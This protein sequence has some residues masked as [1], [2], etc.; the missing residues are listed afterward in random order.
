M[1]TIIKQVMSALLFTSALCTCGQGDGPYLFEEDGAWVSY[2]F[3]DGNLEKEILTGNRMAYELKVATDV[4]GKTFTVRLKPGL[5]YELSGYD[6]PKKLVAI[7]DI[8]GNFGAF[9]KLLQATEV[10][11]RDLKWSFG[12]GHLVLVGDFFDRGEMVT[13]VLWLIYKL[14]H[15]A[16]DEGGQV[17]FIL[18]NHETM[19]LY[20]DLRYVHSKYGTSAKLMGRKPRELYG[21]NT[22]LGQWLRT[23]NVVEKVGNL[24]FAHA[25]VSKEVN[26]LGLSLESINQ[27]T[28][29]NLDTNPQYLSGEIDTLIGYEGVNWYRGYYD[30]NVPDVVDRTLELYDVEHI[31]TGHTVV[32][33]T[34]S[35]HYGVKVINI[36]T[37]HKSGKSEALLMEGNK[38]YRVDMKGKRKTLFSKEK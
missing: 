22:E 17:H 21:R 19:N 38:F 6:M 15:E 9:R 29:P 14:E 7:S 34:I 30:A 36:D 26:G 4:P 32:A 16:W 28:R 18:G 13:E 31:V 23:K 3:I 12:E 27:K 35:T 1:K 37:P 2:S 8:E 20:G 33:D 11:G 5:S 24:L 25:G 10:M